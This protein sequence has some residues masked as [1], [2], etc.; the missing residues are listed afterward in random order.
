MDHL[1]AI[2]NTQAVNQLKAIFGLEA[3]K[4]NRDFA[5]TIAFPRLFP[6]IPVYQFAQAL[7]QQYY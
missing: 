1:I 3:L 7:I 2:N 4:D 5:M 6:N